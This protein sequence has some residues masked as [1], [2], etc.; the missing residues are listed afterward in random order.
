MDSM[1][2]KM[3]PLLRVLRIRYCAIWSF[4]LLLI[5]LFET[6]VLPQGFCIDMPLYTY[7]LQTLGILLMIGCIPVA[8]RLWLW[9][10]KR[11]IG[12]GSFGHFLRLYIR[13]TSIR[14]S[15]LSLS[16][17]T[18]L[19]VYYATLDTTGALCA[20]ITAIALLFCVPTSDK[21]VNE[22]EIPFDE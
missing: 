15:L 12:E 9:R 19:I 3:S 6:D 1:E 18:N 16:L 21:V 22:I 8:L 5:L 7:A 2:D 14:Y 17:Y 4:A 11:Y 13:W 20:G 10:K